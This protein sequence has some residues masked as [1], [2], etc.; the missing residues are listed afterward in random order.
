MLNYKEIHNN[1]INDSQYLNSMD[2]NNWPK[3]IVEKLT[4]HLDKWSSVFEYWVWPWWNSI[5]LAENWYNVEAQDISDKMIEIFRANFK[6]R[7]LDILVTDCLAQ[8]VYHSK[9]YDAFVCTYVLHFMTKEEAL[10]VI[11]NMQYNTNIWWFNAL[12]IFTK[13]NLFSR[14]DRFYPNIQELIDLYTWWTV[15]ENDIS[16]WSNKSINAK[17]LFKK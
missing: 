6:S 5:F 8:D 13:D 12:E 10:K 9:K 14:D 2:P 7:W 1:K 3:Y 11:R 15:I 4:K 16:I 17:I